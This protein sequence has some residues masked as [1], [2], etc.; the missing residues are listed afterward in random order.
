M[1][2]DANLERVVKIIVSDAE[3]N[4]KLAETLAEDSKDVTFVNTYNVSG[5]TTLTGVKVLKDS[6]G[7]TLEL[8]EGQFRFLVTPD[9]YNPV[10]GVDES[11]LGREAFNAAD[12]LDS[13]KLGTTTQQEFQEKYGEGTPAGTVEDDGFD[14]ECA[15]LQ[16]VKAWNCDGLH[17]A[18]AD[19]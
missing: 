3:H 17:Y 15:L 6:T 14:T 16:C 13:L 10:E 18:F 12:T 2:N 7:R 19:D 4:G 1:E 11:E 8:M 9:D 5:E